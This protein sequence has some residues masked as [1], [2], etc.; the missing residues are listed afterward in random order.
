MQSPWLLLTLRRRAFSSRIMTD[1]PQLGSGSVGRG[2]KIRREYVVHGMDRTSSN[3]N[4][5]RPHDI[6]A[7]DIRNSGSIAHIVEDSGHVDVACAELR[8]G[9]LH[10]V[11]TNFGFGNAAI[12]YVQL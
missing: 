7:E 6:P 10:P 3:E 8:Q 4:V 2:I 12:S 11:F 1:V 9:S 5:L